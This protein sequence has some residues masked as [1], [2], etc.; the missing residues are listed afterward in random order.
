[1]S[2][3]PLVRLVL[4]LILILTVDKC[5]RPTGRITNELCGIG[6][7]LFKVIDSKTQSG[8]AKGKK[9]MFALKQRVEK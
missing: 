3:R 1:M 8:L 2:A 5:K 7:Y 9:Y 6:I 4:I